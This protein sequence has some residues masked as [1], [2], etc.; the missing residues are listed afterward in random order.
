MDGEEQEPSRIYTHGRDRLEPAKAALRKTVGENATA[1]PEATMVS[2][3]VDQ[4]YTE[5]YSADETTDAYDGL[6]S[7][8]DNAEGD[9]LREASLVE[10]YNEDALVIATKEELTALETYLSRRESDQY[11]DAK[12]A[13]G[14][15]K[16]LLASANKDRIEKLEAT[17]SVLSHLGYEDTT[18]REFDI[19]DARTRPVYDFHGIGIRE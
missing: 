13:F 11:Y 18:L 15:L 1:I 7:A 5:L 8:V 19:V 17:G 10:D 9:T 6:A 2:S 14:T 12:E 16:H 3:A 4:Y